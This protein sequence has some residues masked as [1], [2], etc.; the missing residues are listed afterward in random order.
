VAFAVSICIIQCA[1][2]RVK[3]A[4]GRDQTRAQRVGVVQ[5]VNR[6][7]CTSADV[8]NYNY[9]LAAMPSEGGVNG[10]KYQSILSASECEQKHSKQGSTA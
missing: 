2:L 3:L 7:N 4:S 6:V 1:W 8:H 9:V 10:I 5:F